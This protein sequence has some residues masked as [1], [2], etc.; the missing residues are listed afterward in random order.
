MAERGFRP[1]QLGLHASGEQGS[2]NVMIGEITSQRALVAV[3]EKV[4]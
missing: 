2:V 4:S 1:G 3:M